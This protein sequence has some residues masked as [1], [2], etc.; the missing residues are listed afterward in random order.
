MNSY[1]GVQ[2]TTP[3]YFVV[4]GT[5]SGYR[6]VNTSYLMTV[7]KNSSGNSAYFYGNVNINGTLNS[8]SVSDLAT[9]TWVNGKGYTT[10]SY[11]DTVV[12]G[13]ATYSYV[14]N[15]VND[16]FDS[17]P[18]WTDD[19]NADWSS[20]TQSI[21]YKNSSSG[22]YGARTGWV[23]DNFEKKSS[24]ER[25]KTNIQDLK[26][27]SAFYNRLS[28]KEFDYKPGTWYADHNG[29]S[30][31]LIAQD[32]IKLLSEFGIDWRKNQIIGEYDTND[33]ELAYGIAK[34]VNAP[35]YYKINYEE[36]HAWHI[37]M[38]QNQQREIEQLKFQN[39]NLQSQ[40]NLIMDRITQLENK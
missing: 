16:L 19:I 34:Y 6:N 25:I 36:L 21:T 27:I 4:N 12:S 8:K 37:Q 20:N 24:D 9:Q 5:S 3:N 39:Q 23:S 15:A 22:Y 40:I 11:V 30:Y 17:I 7:N 14:N 28:P 31:G 1:A 32:V 10:T 29:H 18:G 33:T 2:I 26:D 35:T 13:C 38:I